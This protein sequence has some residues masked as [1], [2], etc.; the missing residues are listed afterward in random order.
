VNGYTQTVQTIKNGICL[1]E[2]GKKTLVCIGINPS[3]AEPDNLDNTLNGVKSR[4]IFLG[5]DS[6]VMINV[7]P[8]RATDPK[9]L[10][11]EINVKIYERNLKEIESFFSKSKYDIWAAWG[12]LI[13]KRSYL[14]TCLDEISRVIGQQSKWFTI[15]KRSK[16]GHPH[17]P[18]YLRKDLPTETFNIEK[19]IKE[20]K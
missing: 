9:D 2:R 10:H 15:G 16:D 20:Q 4:T 8:Q 13:K 11:K 1:G 14:L 17:H 12:T 5:Y 18:L 3:T 7:Y 6:W 19:Y